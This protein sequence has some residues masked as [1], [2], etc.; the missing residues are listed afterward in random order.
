M[1]RAATVKYQLDKDCHPCMGMTVT[2]AWLHF[3]RLGLAAAWP[4]SSCIKD[5]KDILPNA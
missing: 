1:G 4:A 2:M 3:I 5:I